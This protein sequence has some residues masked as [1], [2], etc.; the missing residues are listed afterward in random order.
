MPGGLGGIGSIA[1]LASSAG[2][3]KGGGGG[4]GGSFTPP[5]NPAAAAQQ[6][7]SQY[8]DY[9]MYNSTPR[10]VDQL[11]A[12]NMAGLTNAQAAQN[13]N[14]QQQ[15]L[16]N[17]ASALAGSNAANQQTASADN[18]SSSSNALGNSDPASLGV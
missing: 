7:G 12:V 13:F 4:G 10:L 1:S 8:A 11:G 2:G 17:A 16:N 14:L 18:S 9:G 3:G 15:Q 5:V 6:V